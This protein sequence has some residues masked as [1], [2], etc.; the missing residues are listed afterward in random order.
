M[1]STRNPAL[2]SGTSL[3]A[4]GVFLMQDESQKTSAETL[5]GLPCCLRWLQST[6]DAPDSWKLAVF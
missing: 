4:S 5:A 6:L 2:Y 1:W 3:A